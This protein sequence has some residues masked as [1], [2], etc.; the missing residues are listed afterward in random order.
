MSGVALVQ[1]SAL[2]LNKLLPLA[3][4]ALDRSVSSAADSIDSNPPL[5]HMLCVASIKEP[6]IRPSAKSVI[7]YLNL[8]H[9]GFLIASHERDIAEILEITGMP[10]IMVESVER[11]ISV[12]FI[13]GT[14][15]EW[16]TAILRGCVPTA[17]RE[18]RHT[19]NSLYGEFNKLGLGAM[20]E[21]RKVERNDNT[22][23]LEYHP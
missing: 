3:R 21:A 16:K 14:L 1:F 4:Q 6:D 19:F 11:S 13:A 2:N 20:F 17:T 22:F 10:A 15:Q 12:V 23:L 9:A 5:H 7:P 8:F 18:A